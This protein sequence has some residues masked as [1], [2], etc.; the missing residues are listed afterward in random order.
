MSY[1]AQ[2]YPEPAP[3]RA[4]NER[5]TVDCCYCGMKTTTTPPPA[6]VTCP[7]CKR[8]FRVYTN[9]SGVKVELGKDAV[10]FFEQK[11]AA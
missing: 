1:P 9:F 10:K 8:D 7:G 11:G 5:V 4:A 2:V 3:A 6:L